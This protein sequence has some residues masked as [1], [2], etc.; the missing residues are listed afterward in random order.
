MSTLTG[1]KFVHKF[2]VEKTSKPKVSLPIA[3]K[4]QTRGQICVQSVFFK[5]I[6]F[7]FS[8]LPY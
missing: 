2:F 5:I 7:Y 1:A 6:V 3:N 4:W 8:G